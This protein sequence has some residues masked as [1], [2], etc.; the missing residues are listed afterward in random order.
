[1]Y[2]AISG[3][4][5]MRFHGHQGNASA[6]SFGA[7]S[8]TV[9]SCGED[10]QAYLWSLRPPREKEAKPS[11]DSLWSALAAEPAKAYRALWAMSEDEGVAAFLRAKLAPVKPVANE[12][13]RKLIVDLD[14]STFTVRDRATK[15]LAEL[16]EAAAPA[17]R[18]A[19]TNKPALEMRKRLED[20]I[21]R[22]ER[23][24]LSL[25]ELR[26]VRAIDVLERRGDGQAREL[27]KA[28]ASGAAWALPTTTAKA[29]LKRLAQ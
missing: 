13:L 2:E 3:D 18:E 14:S 26:I 5:V 7:D 17:M 10:A 6:I 19:L 1:L 16:G 28:L 12:R 24:T 21:Q 20:L 22:V 25:D 23:K 15:A 4:E 8:R 27:L 11:L 29:A 9:L